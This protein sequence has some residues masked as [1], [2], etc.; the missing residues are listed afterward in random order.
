MGKKDGQGKSGERKKSAGFLNLP[1]L[2]FTGNKEVSLEG[3]SGILEYDESVVRI[4]SGRLII[5]FRGFSLSIK[6]LT[7][8]SLVITGTITA[9][10]FL[11]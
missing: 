2:E 10:E 9:V 4:N 6:C 5:S 8:S 1:I 11:D 3:V 7:A